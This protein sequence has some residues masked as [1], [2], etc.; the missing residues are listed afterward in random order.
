MAIAEMISS[1]GQQQ[2]NYGAAVGQ[3]L[4]QLGQQV[5]QQLAMKEYQ[6]QASAAL[7]AMQQDYTNAFKKI[8]AGNIAEG[9]TDI[10]NT[11]MQYGSTQNPFLMQQIEQANKMGKDAAN[12]VISQGWQ[13]IQRSQMMAKAAGGLPSMSPQEAATQALLPDQAQVRGQEVDV[14]LPEEEVDL[15]ATPEA[16]QGV[17]EQPQKFDPKAASEQITIIAEG[18]GTK[19][20]KDA[21]KNAAANPPTEETVADMQASV[22]EYNQLDEAGKQSL[23]QSNT[24]TV[25]TKQKLDELKKDKSFFQI[26]NADKIIGKGYNG[27][28]LTP[29]VEAKGTT[30]GKSQS[31]SYGTNAES[32]R[33]FEKTISG[34]VTELNSGKMGDFISNQGGAMNVDVEVVEEDVDGEIKQVSYLVNK[35][36]P[37]VRF[38]ILGGSERVKAADLAIQNIKGIPAELQ[39]LN[40]RGATARMISIPVSKAQGPTREAVRKTKTPRTLDEILKQ[41]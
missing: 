22:N 1:M 8:E 10:L 20:F 16:M 2:A 21:L 18:A 14:P 38:K 9:Y 34:A 23:I 30:I 26:E 41:K 15:E 7:P 12:V 33:T 35:K 32:L 19:V 6:R 27:L 5:G 28:V 31:V 29:S 4:I 40:N 17:D 24:I 25:D 36:N 39:R 37:D 13:D 3:S 11:S